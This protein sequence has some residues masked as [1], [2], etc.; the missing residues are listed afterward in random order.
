[1]TKLQLRKLIKEII[2]AQAPNDMSEPGAAFNDNINNN[3]METV[4]NE[5][6]EKAIND[7]LIKS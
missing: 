7:T 3:S 5:D 6:L 1:M 2:E 4:N